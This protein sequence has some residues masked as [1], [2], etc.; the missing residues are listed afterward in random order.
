M[1]LFEQMVVAVTKCE[2][3]P[4]GRGILSEIRER[5]DPV[6]TKC[7]AVCPGNRSVLFEQDQSVAQPGD[8]IL[9]YQPVD[10]RNL[11]DRVHAS[12]A[13]LILSLL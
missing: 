8:Q 9:Q 6:H 12:P 1:S 7:R 5:L 10:L 2:I 3:S 4:V 11:C 13:I